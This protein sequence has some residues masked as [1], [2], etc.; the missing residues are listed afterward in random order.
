MASLSHIREGMTLE[1]FLKLPEEIP[2]PRVHRRADRGQSVTAEEARADPGKLTRT[3]NRFAGPR[4]I[5]MAFPELR[6]TFAGRSIIP[7][8][9]FLLEEHIELDDTGDVRSMRLR[10]P[11]TSTSRSSRP[12]RRSGSRTRSWST[13]RRT[14]ARSAG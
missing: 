2:L 6:C 10:C 14:A 7:D 13:P 9:V 12:S 1:E 11:P 5:G 3:S 8:V 4:R